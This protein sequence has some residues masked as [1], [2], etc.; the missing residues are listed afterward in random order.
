M[1]KIQFY[2]WSVSFKGTLDAKC[3]F[4]WRL[5]INV[6]AVCEHN[7]PSSSTGLNPSICAGAYPS[8][9]VC[10]VLYSDTLHV[11]VHTL[12]KSPFRPSFL[13]RNEVHL[14]IQHI[15]HLL[16]SPLSVKLTLTFSGCHA[17]FVFFLLTF[18]PL[19][20]RAL[21]AQNN[22]VSVH[23]VPWCFPSHSV[24]QTV[25]DGDEHQRTKHWSLVYSD[26]HI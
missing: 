24:G 26:L 16:S 11:L 7:H 19:I 8:S 2:G 20:S 13:S 23:H 3:T 22:I 9:P 1:L 6:L 4:I 18:M 25:H 21:V 10:R 15:H 12:F 14:S 5:H 17:L